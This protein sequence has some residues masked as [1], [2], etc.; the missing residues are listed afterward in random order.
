MSLEKP[1][2]KLSVSTG[3][4]IKNLE[5]WQKPRHR[6]AHLWAALETRNKTYQQQMFQHPIQELQAQWDRWNELPY[7]LWPPSSD[8]QMHLTV[9]RRPPG[10]E[11]H[12]PILEITKVTST[13]SLAAELH[14]GNKNS[15]HSSALNIGVGASKFLGVQ[16]IFAQIFPNLPKTLS[17]YFCGLFF[18]VTSKKM[19]FTCFFANV[20]RHFCPD[21]QGFCLDIQVIF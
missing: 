13:K 9:L 7:V 6:F 5:Q 15:D 16:K 2:S 17:S 8:Q 4:P 12:L 3:E 1:E 21:F 10:F 14:L 18:G 11:T 20:G 19:V